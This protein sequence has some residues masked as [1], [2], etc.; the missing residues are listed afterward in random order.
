MT[1]PG[2]LGFF[3]FGKKYDAFEAVQ[4]L[5]KKIQIEQN[6]PIMRICSDHGKEF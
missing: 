4:Q 6:C 1:I 3:F 5:F 2:T